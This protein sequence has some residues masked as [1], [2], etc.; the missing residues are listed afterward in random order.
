MGAA[1]GER[2]KRVFLSRESDQLQYS[3]QHGLYCITFPPTYTLLLLQARLLAGSC[4]ATET[5]AIWRAGCQ[6][7]RSSCV[8][9]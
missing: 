3:M 9:V 5:A 1:D 2:G 6:T 4:V 7:T 8:M